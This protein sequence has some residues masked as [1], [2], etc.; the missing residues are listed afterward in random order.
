MRKNAPNI[1]AMRAQVT[2][3]LK[4]LLWQACK[5]ST[6]NYPFEQY[7]GI[8]FMKV[9]LFNV[10]IIIESAE[11]AAEENQIEFYLLKRITFSA[12]SLNHNSNLL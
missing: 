9:Y 10:C 3:I 2:A 4:T 8:L 6:I 11:S 12:F 7:Y 5:V 1:S